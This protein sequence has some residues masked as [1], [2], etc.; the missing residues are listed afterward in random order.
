MGK[1]KTFSLVTSF[2]FAAVLVFALSSS[3]DTIRWSSPAKGGDT[4]FSNPANW[5]KARV[6]QIGDTVI[7]D[8]ITQGSAACILDVDPTI[9]AIAFRNNYSSLF[10]FNSHFLRISGDCADFRSTGEIDGTNNSGGILFCGSSAQQF[11]PGKAHFPCIIVNDKPSGT[12]VCHE[13]GMLA[14]TLILIGGTLVCGYELTHLCGEIR[15]TGGM[16]DFGT[17]S[18]NVSGAGVFLSRLN[19]VLARTGTLICTG[20]GNQ[21]VEFPPDTMTIHAFVQ[22]CPSGCTFAKRS[23]AG[24]LIDSVALLSGSLAVADSQCITLGTLNVVHG[25][26]QIPKSVSIIIQK[27]ADLSGL[28]TSG[29][30]GV[31]GFSGDAIPFVPRPGA[32]IAAI[33][34][35]Q[36]KVVLAG[37]GCDADELRLSSTAQPCT[38][39]LGAHFTHTFRSIS[40]NAGSVIDFGTSTLQFA[41]DT[42]DLS[43]CGVSPCQ[44][45]DGAISFSGIN[46]QGFVPNDIMTYP[47]IIQ[48]GPNPTTIIR[49]GLSCRRLVIQSGTLRLGTGLSHTVTTLLQTNGGTL[50]FGSS[51]MNA[52]ADT[53]DF[54]GLVN[55][56]AASGTLSFIGATGTQI[57]LPKPNVLHPDITKSQNGTV[58]VA[59]ALRAK[60]FWMSAGTFD[61]DGSR[62][63]LTGFSA[64]GGTF[65]TGRDS[66]IITGNANFSDLSELV[67]GNAP[68]V[69]RAS[70]N[71]PVVSFSSTTQ[72][73]GHLVLSSM[74]SLEGIARIVAAKGIHRASRLTFQWNR[75][76][77]SAIFDFRQNGAGLSAED[78]VDVRPE[79]SGNDKGAILMGSGSWTFSGDV[80]LTNQVCDSSTVIFSRSDTRQTISV[81]QPLNNVIHSGGGSLVLGGRLACRNFTQSGGAL[82]FKGLSI[83]STND[84]SLLAG[85]GPSIAPSSLPW[86][87]SAGRNVFLSG[88]PDS[89]LVIGNA[90][91]CTLSAGKS[92]TV[93]SSVLKHC[94][95]VLTKGTAYNSTDSGG[96][97]NWTFITRPLPIGISADSI[98]FGNVSAG[99][100][101]DTIVSLSNACN[102]TVTI[103]LVQLAGSNFSHSIRSCKVLPHRTVYDTILYAPDDAGPDSGRVVFLSNAESSPDTVLLRGIGRGPRLRCSADTVSFGTMVLSRSIFRTVVMKNTGTDTLL[104]S[105]SIQPAD[106]TQD[107]DSVFSVSPAHACAP[108]DSL[109]DTIRFFPSKAGTFFAFLILKTNCLAAY[110]TV[111]ITA[112]GSVGVAEDSRQVM[113]KDFSFQEVSALEKSVLF[114]YG[115]PATSK[116]TLE[117]YDAIGRFLE[118]PIESVF[119]A[120]EYQFVWDASHL[121]RGIYFCRLKATDGTSS[122]SKF[123]KTLRVVFS[124]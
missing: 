105:Q 123:V 106:R 13:V 96:N 48:N 40:A 42:L 89:Q 64:K 11:F 9:D 57:F 3:G 30:Q 71:N 99:S 19:A 78:T 94:A 51:T 61:P 77:D 14:D 50:D 33:S 18:I 66:M 121:S 110:D 124:K 69:V 80:T 74:P 115:L 32:T 116:V 102:D 111:L 60:K 49:N 10:D 97:S 31:L 103:F 81:A 7:F 38:L 90:P 8:S 108:Q 6:P 87:I 44:S 21:R 20:S 73:I 72:T 56:V 52:A 47:S 17:S 37:S 67:P 54:R 36:G 84:F 112:R 79:N 82:D 1:I 58:R 109:V 88:S 34:V 55:L 75:S 59:G 117:I 104:L 95:A 45:C 16:L 4:R 22:N 63:E 62:C 93:R 107:F 46:P 35:L 98:S 100:S 15:G 5:S 119:G 68:V 27:S 70:G 12:V 24:I 122:E 86:K 43:R 120:S 113:P 118:R 76:A 83:N 53:V 65:I 101:R 25:A 23:S 28:D 91:A 2:S 114:K 26:M 85:Y 92:L 39:S 41:G 29:I